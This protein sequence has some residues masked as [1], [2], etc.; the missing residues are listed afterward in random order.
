MKVLGIMTLTLAL[1]LFA[2]QAQAQAPMRLYVEKDALEPGQAQLLL[3]LLQAEYGD[4]DWTLMED[5]GPLRELVLSGNAPDLAICAPKSARPWAKE[6]LL[7]G[8]QMHI[9]SQQRMQRQA[10]DLCVEDET[11]F[12]APLIAH[13]RQMAVNRRLFEQMGLG[14]MLDPQTYPVWYPAQFYQI[15][16]E[17]MIRDAVAMDIWRAQ[18]DTSAALEALSQAFFGGMM[19]SEDGQRC[20]MDSAA[21]GAGVQWLADAVNDGMIGYCPT[22][23]EA[24]MRFLDGETAVYIDWSARL[25]KRLRSRL[26]E[27]GLELVAR[28]YP[29]AVG[30][31]VRSFDLAG[32]CAFAGGDAAKDAR[33]IRACAMLHEQ[34]QDVLGQRGIWQDGAVWPANPDVHEAGATLRS[35]MCAA[36]TEAIEG[37]RP[38]ADALGRVQAAM[39][40]IERT[41]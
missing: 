24:L 1:M 22:R 37:G 9:G 18:P 11:L 27:A 2:G 21:M 19:L 5:T 34:A 28:P 40:A 4:D 36:L 16:E 23:D 15:L 33:L 31:P 14:Y 41:P 13:H 39:D 29:A 8:L 10:L 26:D 6:G 17:F 3:G 20:E 25:E 35:L 30:L 38:A 32:V 12:M 7:L